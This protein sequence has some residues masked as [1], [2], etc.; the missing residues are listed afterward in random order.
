MAAATNNA[1]NVRTPRSGAFV[2]HLVAHHVDLVCD[3]VRDMVFRSLN[4]LI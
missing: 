1:A 3:K 2:A 4:L